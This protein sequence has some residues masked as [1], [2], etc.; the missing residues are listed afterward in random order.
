ML[1]SLCRREAAEQRGSQAKTHAL[2]FEC[3]QS[4]CPLGDLL[5]QRDLWSGDL[6]AGYLLA[7]PSVL[8][9]ASSIERWEVYLVSAM[10]MS[11]TT[12]HGGQ[13]GS[14]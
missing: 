1:S 14:P 11:I 12:S 6:A 7:G 13:H 10:S 8:L 2:I 5:T 4:K 3:V 9:E